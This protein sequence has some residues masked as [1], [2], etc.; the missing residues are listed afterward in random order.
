[1]FL[2]S[3]SQSEPL[4]AASKP[5][6]LTGKA[7][8]ANW[9]ETRLEGRHGQITRGLTRSSGG[10]LWGRQRGEFEGKKSE[11]IRFTFPKGAMQMINSRGEI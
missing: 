3:F 1:M 2:H 7:G 9:W 4:L 5:R 11:K 10:E 6:G 8:E